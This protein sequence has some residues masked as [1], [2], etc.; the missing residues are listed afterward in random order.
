MANSSRGQVNYESIEDL[1]DEQMGESD[2]SNDSSISKRVDY[3]PIEDLFDEQFAK[4]DEFDDVSISSCVYEPVLV[5]LTEKKLESRL[6]KSFYPQYDQEI[7]I[8]VTEGNSLTIPIEDIQ[9]LAFVNLPLQIDLLK[10]DDF[11]EVVETFN[12]DSFKVRISGDQN[13]NTGFFG[14]IEKPEN[15]YKY[16]F[17][18]SRNIKIQYQQRPIGDIFV[19]KNIMSKDTLNNVL[20][21][22]GQLRSLRLGSIIAR[23]ASLQPQHVEET[24][25]N[26]W[27]KRPEKKLRFE[28]ERLRKEATEKLLIEQKLLKKEA[29]RKL[30][31]EEENFKKDAAEKLLQKQKEL[32]KEVEA[33]KTAAEERLLKEIDEK[34]SQEKDELQKKI[35]MKLQ[36]EEER[37]KKE[38]D[39]KLLQKQEELKKEVE[40]KKTAAE[41]RMNKEIDKKLSKEKNELK[42]E[43]EAKKTAAEERM[44]KEIEEKTFQ[45]KERLRALAKRKLQLEAE[46]LKSDTV[47]KL[48]TGDILIEAGI[49]TPEVVKQSL[50]IQ[51]KM[52]EM[53]LGELFI[54]MG[55]VDEEQMCKVLAEKFK[56]RFVNLQKK[57]PTKE[58]LKY[59]PRD[60]IK[61]LKIVPLDL[62][63]ERLVIATSNPDNK[64][65]IDMLHEKLSCPFELVVSPSNQI[66]EILSNLPA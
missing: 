12:G 50:A 13:F 47:E 30:Q 48:P 5:S 7:T 53:K 29:N 59:L 60:L 44:K 62:N 2:E 42:K 28:K 16:I 10:I 39:E 56:K 51:K 61:K 57:T 52:R 41:E 25:K 18:P 32:M 27:E 4:P 21:K 34:L 54:E 22:Q 20:R 6:D 31:V 63:N 36:L 58:A 45:K 49:V 46:W 11:S 66:I 64:E 23:R 43:V 15:R 40:A 38:A 8:V 17:F 1:F 9:F 3:E 24:L 26:V 14:I 37:L 33:K 65:L 55:I 19:K 35:N